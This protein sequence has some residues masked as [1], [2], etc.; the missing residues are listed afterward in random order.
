MPIV[1]DLFKRAKFGLE[2]WNKNAKIKNIF[3]YRKCHVLNREGE[4]TENRG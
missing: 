4:L 2:Y 1:L 3:P